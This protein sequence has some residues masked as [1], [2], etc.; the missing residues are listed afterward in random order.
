MGGSSSSGSRSLGDTRDLEE[1][2]KKILRGGESG[3]KNVFISFAYEDVNEVNLLRGQAKNEKSEIEFNDGSV[4]EPF[5]SER[6]EYIKQKIRER[7]NR[8]S[9]TIVYLS[10][11]TMNSRWV[12]WE[13]EKSL[14]LGRRIIAV[15]SGD[16]PPRDLPGFV[17]EHKIKV[18]PWSRLADALNQE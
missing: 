8:C 18:I 3:C 11:A 4:R 5:D 2:A 1:R 15:H 17:H 16:M 9:I 13:V 10:P 6:S 7:I 12:R 14:E